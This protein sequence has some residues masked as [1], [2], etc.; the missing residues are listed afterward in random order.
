MSKI[1]QAVRY[2]REIADA[3]VKAHVDLTN[4]QVAATRL[5]AKARAAL[6]RQ[7]IK[8]ERKYTDGQFGQLN[9]VAQEHRIFHERE[10]ILYEQAIEKAASSLS[11][12]LATIQADVDRLRLEATGWMTVERFERE[13]ASLQEKTE[14]ADGVLEAKILAEEKITVRSQAQ[15]ELLDKLQA[16]NRWLV[17]ISL[18]TGLTLLGLALHVFGVY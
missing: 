18:S 16:N 8:Y 9:L 12:G 10:H 5:E 3:K 17:T 1:R 11:S 13:H 2:E 15:Q 4:A 7:A 14:L 6:L